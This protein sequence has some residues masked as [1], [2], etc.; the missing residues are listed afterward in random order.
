MICYKCSLELK[1]VQESICIVCKRPTIEGNTHKPCIIGDTP[2]S[3]FSCFEYEGKVR[4]GIKLSKYPPFL[5]GAIEKL[6]EYGMGYATSIG[7]YLFDYLL[8]PIPLSRKKFKKR[9]FNQSQ[10]ISKKMSKNLGLKT[11]DSILI[12]RD[13]PHAKDVFIANSTITRNKKILLVYDVCK[14]G[15]TFLSSSKALYAAGAAEVKC[16]TLS[17]VL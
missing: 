1:V 15:R 9:G 5:F 13:G 6:T 16:F 2:T 17:R 8:V 12:R 4:K 10:K 11:N 7:Y 14:T 3:L